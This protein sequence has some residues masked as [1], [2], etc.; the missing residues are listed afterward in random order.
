MKL[1][2]SRQELIEKLSVLEKALPGKGHFVQLSGFHFSTKDGVAT[3]TTNNIDMAIQTRVQIDGEDG[4]IVL[5]NSF[6]DIV[7]KLSGSEVTIEVEDYRARVKSGKTKFTLETLDAEEFPLPNVD[8]AQWQKV[9]FVGD[10]LK[11]IIN[12]TAPFAS[13]DESKPVFKGVKF[14]GDT[15]IA[16]DTYRLAKLELE[17]GAD[18]IIPGKLLQELSKMPIDDV[19][20]HL[21]EEKAVFMCGEYTVYLSVLSG[22]F[23]DM[24][25]VVPEKHKTEVTVDREQLLQVLGRASIIAKDYNKRIDVTIRDGVMTVE[26]RHETGHMMDEIEVEQEGEDVDTIFLNLIYFQEGAR[27]VGEKVKINF[28]GDMG[29]VVINDDGYINLILPIKKEG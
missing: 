4:E 7:R 14:N 6:A 13:K 23:P 27:S 28:N 11:N 20:A 10:K 26:A 18:V 12:K 19:I 21:G 29:P 15:V 22:N 3:I 8:Y 25:K 17:T 2:I 16:T 24:S 1:R 9:E 5:D